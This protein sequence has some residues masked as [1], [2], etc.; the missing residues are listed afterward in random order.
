[1]EELALERNPLKRSVLLF[2][3]AIF[4]VLRAGFADSAVFNIGPGDVTRLIDAINT[5][6]ANGEENTINLAAA[7]DTLTAI[8]NG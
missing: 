7:T 8:D 3:L 1:M 2:S 4:I 5:A 6:N